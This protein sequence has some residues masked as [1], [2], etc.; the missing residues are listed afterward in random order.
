MQS[1]GDV[2]TANPQV[3]EMHHSL[4][5]ALGIMQ[6][7]NCGAVPIVDGDGILHGI[8]TDRDIA[9]CLL[10]NSTKTPEELQIKDCVRH[11]NHV[12]T[13]RPDDEIHYAVAL[14][15]EHQVRRLPVCDDE[16]RCVGII[17]QADI[18]LK[19]DRMQEVVELV[20]EIS[21]DRGKT[22]GVTT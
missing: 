8:V 6:Q 2:M 10:E 12:I 11:V 3:C 18:A 17:T 15:E 14:M 21:K 13:V 20:Q 7:A 4:T 9:L 22:I 1:V 19:D 16:T 5:C